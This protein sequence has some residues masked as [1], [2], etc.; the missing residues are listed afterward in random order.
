M[1]ALTGLTRE[2]KPELVELARNAAA[3]AL[4]RREPTFRTA[5][6]KALTA[7]SRGWLVAA[8]L[9]A[10]IGRDEQAA[11]LEV[12]IRLRM[13]DLVVPDL[14]DWAR[15]QVGGWSPFGSMEARFKNDSELAAGFRELAGAARRR[16]LFGRGDR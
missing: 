8:W 13:G 3:G 14:D 10:R 4:G 15:A 12:A 7:E 6:V 1:E 16:R 9:G 11:L 5:L 2:G